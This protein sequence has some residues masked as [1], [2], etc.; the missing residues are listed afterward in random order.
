[1]PFGSFAYGSGFISLGGGGGAVA[2]YLILDFD[3][4]IPLTVDYIS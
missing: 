4:V 1:M 3:A 2:Y